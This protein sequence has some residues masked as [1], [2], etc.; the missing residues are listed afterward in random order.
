MNRCVWTGKS[1]SV[2]KPWGFEIQW[3][4]IF[5]GKELHLRGNHKTS[6]K[7][8]KNKQEVLYVQ[9]GLIL[10]E[11]ADEAHFTDPGN[12]PARVVELGPG[13]L[14]NVQAGCA[15]RLTAIDDSVVFEIG[16]GSDTQPTRL[17]DDYGRAIDKSKKYIFV[18]PTKESDN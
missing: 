6:L 17:E 7:F 9:S 15:Y 2:E 12:Y 8:H 5:Q 14:L 1:S 16:D 13:D 18:H 10:A 4:G 3:C 11:M